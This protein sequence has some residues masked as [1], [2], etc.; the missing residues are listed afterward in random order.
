MSTSKFCIQQRQQ[1]QQQLK[2]LLIFSFV[3]ST[4]LHGIGAYA[5]PHLSVESPQAEKPM[6]LIIVDQPKP[7]PK[8]K[9]KAPELKI[10]SQPKIESKPIVKSEPKP[11][12]QPEA[13]KAETPPPPVTKPEPIKAETPPPP[14]TKPEPVKAET[15]PPPVPNP[16]PPKPTPQKVLTAPTSAP[17]QSIVSAP[18]ENASEPT[19]LSNSLTSATSSAS[20]SAN[21]NN[22]SSNSGVRGEVATNSNNSAPS[23]TESGSGEGIACVSNCEPEYPSVLAGIEGTAGI[24]LTIAPDGTVTSVTIASANDNS[25][26]NRQALLAARQMEFSSPPGGSSASV[27]VKIDFTVAG[28]EFDR[29]ARQEQQERKE[30]QAELKQELEQEQQARQLQLK[31]ER[32][33]RARQQQT[34]IEKRQQQALPATPNPQGTSSETERKDEMLRKFRERIEQGQRQ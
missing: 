28:S 5:L 30:Q 15:P 17:S 11:I 20:D 3:G 13:I 10:K 29:I 25:E 22:S 4:L 18:I 27:Q 6:E 7:K 26:I 16:E 33:A 23:G 34:E 19:P 12:P 8:P 2:K 24:E 14:V 21:S 9:P 1:E 31:Q 32:Q